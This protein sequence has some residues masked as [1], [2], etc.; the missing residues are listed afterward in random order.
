MVRETI[1]KQFGRLI[2]I[3]GGEIGRPG[4]P[5]ET[6]S[7][8]LE[9]IRLTGVSRPK[10]LFI[11]TASG[12]S[13]GYM[14]V[15][16]EHFGKRL[17]C[18][19]ETLC[20]ISD[21]TLRNGEVEQ[22]ILSADIVYVGGGNTL[23]MMRIWRRHKV[24]RILHQAFRQGVV[25]SGVSAGAICWFDSGNSDSLKFKSDD[26]QMMKVSG[27]GIV[28]AL[29]C[30]HYDFE[31]HRKSALKIMMKKTKGVAIAVDNCA[32]I[33]IIGDTYRI[34]SAKDTANAYKVFWSN[35]RFFELKIPKE[36]TFSQLG[37]LLRKT[38]EF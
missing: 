5:V 29:F 10:L 13:E 21:K 14:D 35:D 22:K 1:S 18:Q 16:H 31:V 11:P 26:A 27:L 6:T 28:P 3:G 32:A 9:I 17:E 30:P 33:E 8:D 4:Y 2:A 15:V 23:K 19:V 36:G 20:L 24:D 7:I 34:I 37:N 12:D 38:H 25:L